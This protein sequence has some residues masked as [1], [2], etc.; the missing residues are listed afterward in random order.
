MK[1]KTILTIFMILS[2]IGFLTSLYLVKNHY[3]NPVE[4]A[5]CDVSEGV[6]CSLVNTSIYSE[7]FGA[8]VALFGALWFVVLFLLSWK[9]MKKD[10]ILI[11]AILGWNIFGFLFVIYLII[12]EI[13]LQSI[14]PFCTLVHIIVVATLVWSVF[15]YKKH[16]EKPSW[17]KFSQRLKGWFAIIL[18]INIIPLIAFNLPASEKI[19][20]DP[21]TKC[22]T[23]NGVTMYGSFRCGVCARTRKMFGSSFQ[24]VKEIECHPQGENPQTELCIEKGIEGTP[25]WVL[26]QDGEELKRYTG[27]LSIKELREFSGCAV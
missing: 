7:L 10:G 20:Y 15:L 25:T 13:I 22:M 27:F 19:N 17:K 14:C 21:L 2:V 3:D 12:A 4:G 18:I 24:Y 6:S 16:G 5:F 1:K 8:P 11:T 26:E 9:A 23:E